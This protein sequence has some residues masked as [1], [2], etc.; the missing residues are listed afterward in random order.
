MTDNITEVRYWLDIAIKAI[1]GIV[2]SVVGLDYKAMKT[3]LGELQEA[4]Y[5]L[6]AQISVIQNE[7]NGTRARLERMESKLDKVLER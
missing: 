2:V 6:T 4:K 7:T 1:I 5:L 3:T